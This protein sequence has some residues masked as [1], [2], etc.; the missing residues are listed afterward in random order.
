MA[1]DNRKIIIF[2]IETLPNLPMVLRH[3]PKIDDWNGNSL[4]ASINSVLCIGWKE[5]GS[6]KTNLISA[7]DSDSWEKSVNDDREVLIKFSKVLSDASAIVSH[8]GKRFDWRFIQTRLVMND[9]RPLPPIQH[10]DTK[11]VSKQH[12]FAISNRLNDVAEITKAQKKLENGG[13]ELWERVWARDPKAIKLMGEYCKQDVRTL[14]QVFLKLRPFIKNL[15]NANLFNLEGNAC[16]ICG[17][18]KIVKNGTRVETNGI[19]QRWLCH[20]C[21]SP[22]KTMKNN[23]PRPL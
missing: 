3:L 22:F 20:D 4:K 18:L 21:F 23:S 9:L 17:S 15:P 16:P 14:E 11:Q 12:L 1:R 7:W 13:W 19:R 10:I 6:K 2:D 5:L 8:N